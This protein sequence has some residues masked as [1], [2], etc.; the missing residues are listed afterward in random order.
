[1]SMR[2]ESLY[3]YPIKSFRGVAAEELEIDAQGPRHDRQFML[4]D[5]NNKFITL[6][7]RPELARIALRMNAANSI[8]LSLPEKPE[9]GG[10]NFSISER[11]VSERGGAERLEREFPVIIFKDTVPAY[12]VRADVSQW[13]SEVCERRVRLVR[14]SERAQRQFDARF[15]D[16]TVRFVDAQPLLVLSTA[17]LS[18]LSARAGT[19]FSM[20][21]FRP[22]IVV[23]DVAAHAEDEW[24]EFQ[25]AGITFKFVELCS[26]CK[27]TTVDPLTGAVTDE[28]LKTLTTY[29]RREGGIMFGGY[30][31]HL[32]QGRLRCGDTLTLPQRPAA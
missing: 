18:G 25:A 4:V 19:D 30:Y 7:Q 14:M 23:D 1:M 6:R 16:R 9:L 20:S 28:P 27:L 3:F 24:G 2:I 21:R 32:Q 22:N 10:V 26:R 8:E 5:E 15:L 13:L 12:E 11:P 17:S 31:A 29:R